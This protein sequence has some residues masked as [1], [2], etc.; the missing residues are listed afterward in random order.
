MSKMK[1]FR[2]YFAAS[3]LLALISLSGCSVLGVPTTE[4]ADYAV[5]EKSEGIEVRQYPKMVLVQTSSDGSWK[6]SRRTAFRRLFSYISG[7]NNSKQSIA[8]TAPSHV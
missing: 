2:P 8:M 3:L 4:E 7:E 6:E 5:I 1:T